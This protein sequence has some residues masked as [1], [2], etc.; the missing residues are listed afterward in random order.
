MYFIELMQYTEKNECWKGILGV[1]CDYECL[2]VSSD[3]QSPITGGKLVKTA[4]L[5]PQ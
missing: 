5:M 2:V 4:L 3:L 1:K